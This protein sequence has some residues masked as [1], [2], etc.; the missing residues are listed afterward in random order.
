[1][2][3]CQLSFLGVL[4]KSVMLPCREQLDGASSHT[5]PLLKGNLLHPTH[6]FE[7]N[8]EFPNVNKTNHVPQDTCKVRKPSPRE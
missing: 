7:V 6:D 3:L 5:L 2:S 4:F 1:M 8:Y